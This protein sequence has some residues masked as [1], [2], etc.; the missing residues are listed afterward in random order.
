MSTKNE[1]QVVAEPGTEQY[2]KT[3]DAHAVEHAPGGSFFDPRSADEENLAEGPKSPADPNYLEALRKTEGG[4]EE[5]DALA[6]G[7][8][9]D[10]TYGPTGDVTKAGDAEKPAE[11]SARKDDA[12][13]A[14]HTDR[15]VDVK[16][17]P[18]HAHKDDG[19]K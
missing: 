10:R 8:D 4:Q 5:I 6:Q 2:T 9:G 19:K 14:A 17:Q 11:H 12:K 3:G 15:N 13:P 18:A 7:T 1:K 16:V